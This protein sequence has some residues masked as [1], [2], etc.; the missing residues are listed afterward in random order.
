MRKNPLKLAVVGFSIL[1]LASCI[2]LPNNTV[3][4]PNAKQH[5]EDVNNTKNESDNLNNDI[6]SITKQVQ[7]FVGKNAQAE[8]W[9]MCG[10]SHIDSADQN[11]HPTLVITFDGTTQCGSPARI[12]S[13]QVKIELI[14]GQHWLDANSQLRITHIDYKVTYVNLNNHYLTFNGTK[15]LT[16]LQAVDW[17]NYYFS[18]SA[19]T[20]IRERSYDVTVTFENGS[21]DS[22]NSARRTEWSATNFTTFSVTVYG[23]TTIGGKT[24]DS[25]GTTRFGTNFTTEMITPWVSGTTCGWW[26]PTQGKY[27]STTD[28]FTVTATASVNQQG[29]VVSGCGGYGYKLEWDYANGTAS[30]NAVIQYF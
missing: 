14:A 1:A 13:G 28:N 4:D 26:R 12:R 18:G 17:L 20:Q 2:K 8:A 3:A 23:D 22:W 10:I 30:G 9:T 24:I 5:N 11:G 16:C 25:W 15:Y 7:S 19:A 6:N 27:T 29:N 21:T